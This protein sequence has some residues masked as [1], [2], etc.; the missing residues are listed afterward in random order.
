MRPRVKQH[1]DSD[2]QT[3]LARVAGSKRR[4]W[5][6]RTTDLLCAAAII[7][8]ALVVRLVY[9]SEIRSIPFFD[10]PVGDARG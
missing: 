5:S 8:V 7:G 1:I 10:Q 9:L 6:I 3:P 4:Q 2:S